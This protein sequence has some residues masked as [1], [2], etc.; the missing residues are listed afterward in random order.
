MTL[1]FFIEKM[2][3]INKRLGKG[4]FSYD[5]SHAH[6]A[7]DKLMCLVLKKLGYKK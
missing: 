7:S 3:K 5:E 1:I 6:I 2:E 4:G